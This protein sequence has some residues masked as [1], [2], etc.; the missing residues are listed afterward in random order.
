MGLKKK[1]Q[2]G[3]DIIFAVATLFGLALFA[4]IA[5]YTYSEFVTT[6]KSSETF[7][8]TQQAID[9][10]EDIED[11]NDMWDYVITVILIGFALAIIILGYFIDVSSI[12]FPFY[13][14]VLLI[15]LVVATTLQYVWEQISGTT[16]FTLVTSSSYPIS[17]H[18][19]TNLPIYFTIIGILGLVATYAK[20]RSLRLQ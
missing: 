2:S 18:I 10:L 19:L 1:S 14:I 20:T 6:A 3:T 15:G 11:V 17:N 8:Q 4:L 13:I 12:F 9:V 7:N 16:T 5:T